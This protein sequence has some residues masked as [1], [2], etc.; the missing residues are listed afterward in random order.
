VVGELHQRLA[1][2]LKLHTPHC[3]N[4]VCVQVDRRLGWLHP[5]ASCPPKGHRTKAT[6]RLQVPRHSERQLAWS[7]AAAKS[8]IYGM[9]FAASTPPKRTATFTLNS[10]CHP[11]RSAFHTQHSIACTARSSADLPF[12]SPHTHQAL[13]PA[14]VTNQSCCFCCRALSRASAAAASC[15][16]LRDTSSA[17]G[18]RAAAAADDDAPAVPRRPPPLLLLPPTCLGLLDADALGAQHSTARHEMSQSVVHFCGAW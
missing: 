16:L 7:W 11:K 8:R 18:A 9:Q 17:L 14:S 4:E 15:S 5:Q 12:C 10:P 3:T 6:Q 2:V 1:D 13:C